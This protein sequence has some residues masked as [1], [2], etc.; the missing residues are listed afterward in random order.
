MK[1]YGRSL[2]RFKSFQKSLSSETEFH[3]HENEAV[4]GTYFHI[5]GLA[6]GLVFIETQKLIRKWTIVILFPWYH[7]EA[8]YSQEKNDQP[9]S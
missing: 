3:L 6:R 7:E 5:N 1:F 9:R 8:I 2:I 4:A